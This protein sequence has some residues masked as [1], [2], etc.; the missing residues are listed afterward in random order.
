MTTITD[1]DSNRIQA[2]FLKGHLKL[3][4]KGLKARGV[5]QK[6]LFEKTTAITG[7]KYKRGQF[8]EAIADL[9]KILDEGN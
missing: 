8:E 3:Q 4:S 6:S 1:P 7:K 2:V 9:Q 5:S